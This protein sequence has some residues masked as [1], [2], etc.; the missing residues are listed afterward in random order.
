MNTN[1]K[2]CHFTGVQDVVSDSFRFKGK[3]GIGDEVY[4]SIRVKKKLS[5]LWEAVGTAGTAAVIAGSAPVA[6]TFFAPTGMLAFVGIGTAATPVG[7][8]VA[9]GIV[10][11]GGW[12]GVTR[13]LQKTIGDRA[14]T[15][16]DFINT[17]IDALA[18][19]LFDLMAPLAL[20]VASVDGE[21]DT[22]EKT[23][24]KSYF[25]NS[26][27]F[28]E[29]FVE[30][31]TAI[32]ESQLHQYSISE[33]AQL[34]ANFQKH[35]KDCNYRE[36]SRQLLIFLR[37]IIEADGHIDKREETA[38]ADVQKVLEKNRPVQF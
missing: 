18:L 5:A 24:I 1:E 20:K 16:P 17:P 9:A 6:S 36:M 27:G 28:N 2:R 8:L 19:A 37:E 12:I 14:T 25:V 26:W 35:N 29:A 10:A 32:V 21:I 11:G 34:L 33:Q 23:S 31:G 22:A 15:V 38:I 7:W 3:L 13:Y 30:E 4:T